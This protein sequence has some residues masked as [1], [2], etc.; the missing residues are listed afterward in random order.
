MLFDTARVLHSY[1]QV[2]AGQ[3]VPFSRYYELLSL[4]VGDLIVDTVR[5]GVKQKW[6]EHAMRAVEELESRGI[7]LVEDEER[8]DCIRADSCPQTLEPTKVPPVPAFEDV[9]IQSQ[10]TD[11]RRK[12][13][14]LQ[15]LMIPCSRIRKTCCKA[16]DV[17]QSCRLC[18]MSFH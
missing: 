12:R 13:T 10:E 4:M 11:Q 18:Q 3:C 2:T 14:H 16:D 17:Q 7:A 15:F 8:E 1:E 6:R 5:V 9:V